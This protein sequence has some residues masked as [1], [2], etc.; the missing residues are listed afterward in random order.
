MKV[1][2]KQC[3]FFFDGETDPAKGMYQDLHRMFPDRNAKDGQGTTTELIKQPF[4][5][6]INRMGSMEKWGHA[7]TS[8]KNF[9]RSV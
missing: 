1:S 4:L 9:Q 8:A 2:V 5:I 3:I 7:C 6:L